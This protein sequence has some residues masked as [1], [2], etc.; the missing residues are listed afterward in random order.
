MIKIGTGGIQYQLFA[1]MV[2]VSVPDAK[3]EIRGIAISGEDTL[4]VLGYVKLVGNQQKDIV[5]AVRE[6]MQT[7]DWNEAYINTLLEKEHFIIT[8]TS[9]DTANCTVPD[10]HS[11]LLA[12]L[13]MQS[14]H[15]EYV[16][17]ES[18]KGANERVQSI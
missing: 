1:G 11:A 7:F 2:W 18:I 15:T 3:S 9:G 16:R 12:A 17:I 8:Y 13:E 14:E 4:N 10:Y 5:P 6:L